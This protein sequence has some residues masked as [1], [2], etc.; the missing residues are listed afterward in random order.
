[1]SVTSKTQ[2]ATQPSHGEARLARRDLLKGGIATMAGLAGGPALASAATQLAPPSSVDVSRK[3]RFAKALADNPYLLG[4]A[5]A[6]QE[7]FGP[8][9]VAFTGKFPKELSGVLFRN[10]AGGHEIGDYRYEHWFDGDGMLQ[11]YSIGEGKLQHRGRFVATRKRTK[12]QAAGRA[13]YPG[14][15]S[16]PPDPAG[17]TSPD[18]VNPANI[19]VLNHHGKLFALWEAGSPYE[20]DPDTLETRGIH[21]FSEETQG[22]PFS[23]HPR[24]DPDGN[25]WNFGY[26][27]SAN[28]LI[29]WHIGP[30]GSLKKAGTVKV[31][32]MSMPHDFVV[33][34]NHI[35][36]LIPPL[37]HESSS[38][39]KPFLAQH[40]WHP[41]QATRA[42]VIDKNDF[43]SV[44]TL[45]LPAQW[46]FHYGNGYDNGK[47]VI[48][49]D[50]ARA[51]DPSVMFDQFREIMV[52]N[53]IPDIPAR[54]CRYELNLNTGK[55]TETYLLPA[56]SS[57]E[58]PTIDP[59]LSGLKHSQVTCLAYAGGDRSSNG[60]LNSVARLNIDSGDWQRYRYPDHEL[61]EEHL[62]VAAPGSEPDSKGW[63]IG[64]FL[65]V[66]S[67]QTGLNVFNAQAI[68]DGPIAQARLPYALP[69]GLHGKFVA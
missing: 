11:R 39:P 41:E 29:L 32:P 3:A 20:I 5:S 10:G 22:V 64:S 15:D 63:V 43:S 31:A 24:V 46:V 35:V 45:E 27:S 17:M 36:I 58:F 62:F 13:L 55:A 37:N 38:E 54:H 57:T 33:T 67:K 26:F 59:R 19:S 1:M 60:H 28:L 52:G 21:S 69:L 56:G 14:F 50:A 34:Q 40:V 66:R 4:Y 2:P 6:D 18:D 47:G 61:P 16:I 42:L 25:L 30:D 8:T 12:E 51:D 44:K 7:V 23:A 48:T 53:V 68:A 65:D 49:F 9:T